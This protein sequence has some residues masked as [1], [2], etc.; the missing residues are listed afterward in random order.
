MINRREFISAVGAVSLAPTMNASAAELIK[1]PRLRPG[2]RVGLVS[3]ATAAF[4]TEGTMIW[5][6]ALESLGFEVVLGDHYFD[7]HGYF[8]GDD[9]ARASDINAF[10]AAP[11]IRMI[12]ARGGWGS[13]RLLPLLDYD[14][15]RKN[16]K[17]LLGYSDATALLSAV[18]VQTGLVTFHGPSPLN[19]FS[20]EHF[21]R[22]VMNGE[23]YTL[24]NPTFL[25]ENTL[26]QTE[27]RI[28]TITSGKS[29][30]PILG[31]NLSLL[32]AVTGSGYLPDFEGSILFIEDVDEAVYRVDRM[33]TEL[34][35]SGVLGK[36]AGFVFGRCTECGPGGGFGS[37]TM[38][39]MVAEHI[40]PLGI[41]AF[42]GTMIG[43]IDEQFTIP[44]GID[45]EIDADAGTIELLE[46]AVS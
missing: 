20:A 35:L 26:V 10:F 42:S 9:A 12:F 4:E 2:D 38:E 24:E 40:K 25:T 33:M 21:R 8:A 32:T 11:E 36:I 31:G 7:Q 46:S 15:I 22:V 3:P 17:V 45:V 29:R 28:R 19:V 41:P 1:P 13:P 27:N 23:Q 43:H 37:L 6:E 14:L 39:Q 34:A 16:P 30:G 44:L 18:H 5:V